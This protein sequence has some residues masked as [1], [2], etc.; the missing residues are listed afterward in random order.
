MLWG[1]HAKGKKSQI[2]NK[3]K[4]VIL[5][6]T[7]PSPLGANQGGWFGCKHFSKANDVIVKNGG[8]AIDWNL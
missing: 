6:A 7:H 5:E 1:G 8:K 3:T 2:M 4:H